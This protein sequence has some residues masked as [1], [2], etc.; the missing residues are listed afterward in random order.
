FLSP[1][2]RLVMRSTA[3]HCAAAPDYPPMTRAIAASAPGLPRCSALARRDKSRRYNGADTPRRARTV[4]LG[5]KRRLPAVPLRMP[6]LPPA[7]TGGVIA[8]PTISV[9]IARLD[10]LAV[11]NSVRP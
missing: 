10:T 1:S 2:R 8:A 9:G 4:L 5:A 3:R 11:R 6:A 7:V